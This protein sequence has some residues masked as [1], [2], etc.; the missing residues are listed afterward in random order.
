MLKKKKAFMMNNL[1]CMILSLVAITISVCSFIILSYVVKQQINLI[2]GNMI[3]GVIIINIILSLGFSLITLL[4]IL[5]GLREKHELKKVL[6]ENFRL[7]HLE[8]FIG[9]LTLI[10]FIISILLIM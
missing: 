9:I 10:L 4:C 1:K 6:L 2:I 3:L 8:I 5:D 7:R